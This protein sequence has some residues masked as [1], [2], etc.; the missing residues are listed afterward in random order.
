[1]IASICA[2]PYTLSYFGMATNSLTHCQSVSQCGCR[3][4]Q[5]LRRA[6]RKSATAS[7]A[8]ADAKEKLR[9]TRPVADTAAAGLLGVT[10]EAFADELADY[11]DSNPDGLLNEKV[12]LQEL[13]WVALLRWR[14]K[15][16][17]RRPHEPIHC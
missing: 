16:S 3:R 13:T 6:A 9:A 1:M 12:G 11:V 14:L 7:S 4:R 5:K 8:V 17:R 15:C 2:I 10:S